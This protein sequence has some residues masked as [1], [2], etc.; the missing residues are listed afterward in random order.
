MR[1]PW[2]VLLN[3]FFIFQGSEAHPITVDP[4]FNCGQFY[5]TPVTYRNSLLENKDLG[6]PAAFC[7]PVLLHYHKTKSVYAKLFRK[8]S[9]IE[10]G[11]AEIKAFG[12]DGE[13]A[14][15]EALKEAYPGASQ[16]RCY[17]HFEKNVVAYLAKY[18]MSYGIQMKAD[19]K[20][21]LTA[22][23]TNFDELYVNLINKYPILEGYLAERLDIMKY[24]LH[25][26]NNNGKLFYT[27][28]S[29]SVNAKLKKFLCN[30]KSDILTMLK[31]LS[32]FFASEQ[33]SAIDGYTG[34]SKTYRTSE[35]FTATFGA[36]VGVGSW[37]NLNQQEREKMLR[38]FK[39]AD[40]QQNATH[41]I[42]TDF[43]IRPE[44][45]EI[46]VNNLVLQMMFEKADRILS[47]QQVLPAPTPANV[48]FRLYSCCSGN[49]LS[50]YHVWVYYSGQLNCECR[51]F[52]IY[53]ICSHS[54]AAA[55]YS[56][57]LYLAIKWHRKKYT[58]KQQVAV[59]TFLRS[60]NTAT[61]TRAGLKGHERVRKRKPMH[62]STPV[63]KKRKILCP[64][65]HDVVCRLVDITQHPQLKTCYQCV[66][67]ISSNNYNGIAIGEKVYR[68]YINKT[69]RQPQVSLK[70]Q[71]AYCHLRCFKKS[72]VHVCSLAIVTSEVEVELKSNNIEVKFA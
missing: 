37:D 45:C 20:E 19:L 49:N 7:G 48:N 53:H 47:H 16:L 28:A 12:T 35:L 61:I 11:L 9:E 57:D 39:T 22:D 1:F 24:S 46:N 62:T 4:T 63:S 59:G 54:I 6:T 41:E 58:S 56:R 33:G 5:I 52:K 23:I 2:S 66:T 38:K 27:N 55:H 17:L 26:N 43:D 68:S 72:E 71:W 64:V 42:T 15:I 36:I 14:L 69:T 51:S 70:K 29:E 67:P 21:L 30:K 25:A 40:L 3:I 13:E 10:P 8:L 50:N 65:D 18:K 31:N 44:Q 32:E 60:V 34:H